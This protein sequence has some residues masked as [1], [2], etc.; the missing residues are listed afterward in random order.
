MTN[1]IETTFSLI[2]VVVVTALLSVMLFALCGSLV[3]VLLVVVLPAAFIA[4]TMVDG[5][6]DAQEHKAFM[7]SIR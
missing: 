7:M 5:Y 6:K 3:A 4:Y 2:A 1:L